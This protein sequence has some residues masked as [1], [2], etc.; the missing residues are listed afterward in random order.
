MSILCNE[1]L[2]FVP[3]VAYAVKE[4]VVISGRYVETYKYEV[5]YY[6]GF[7]RLRRLKPFVSVRKADKNKL[8]ADNIRRTKQKIRRLVNSNEKFFK[9][10]ITLTYSENCQDLEKANKDF[11]NFIKR[12]RRIY[13]D[14]KYIAV[15]EF[16]KRGAVHYHVLCNISDFI[17]ND[18]FAKIWTHGFVK[19]SHVFKVDNLGAYLVKYLQKD[20]CDDRYFT[21]NKYFFSKNLLVPVIIDYFKNV[22]YV[23]QKVSKMAHKLIFEQNICS[24]FLGMIYYKQLK[25]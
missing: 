24:D 25:V 16:Q 21:K 1:D 11:N 10:F 7:P 6:V 15:P 5:P 3:P 19:L 23:L 14:L 22:D 8:R 9:K 20:I 18:E 4:K 12:L 2:L 17:H 13:P